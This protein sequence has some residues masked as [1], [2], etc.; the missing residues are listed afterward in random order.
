MNA[1]LAKRSPQEGSQ[2][3]YSSDA[4]THLTDELM[5]QGEPDHRLVGFEAAVGTEGAREGAEE[6]AG[7]QGGWGE[8]VGEWG[9]G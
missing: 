2:D 9:V 6:A 1:L 7:C 3:G 8:G 5:R 4:G